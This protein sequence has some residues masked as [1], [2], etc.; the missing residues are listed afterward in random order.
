MAEPNP[1]ATGPLRPRLA[2][3]TIAT[4]LSMK[5]LSLTKD[6]NLCYNAFQESRVATARHQF[7]DRTYLTDSSQN[8]GRD[9]A[10]LQ[11]CPT[12][13]L[14]P[15]FFAATVHSADTADMIPLDSES[16]RRAL[17][18]AR[19]GGFRSVKLKSGDESFQAVFSAEA[20][21]W[22][23]SFADQEG[24]PDPGPRSGQVE[25]P[26]VG[27][28]RW[29]QGTEVGA[30]IAV[31]QAV[32]EVLALGIANEIVSAHAGKVKAVLTEDGAAVE[33]GQALLEVQLS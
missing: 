31:G 28:V 27:I 25:A 32:G 11:S 23:E 8:L 12:F 26:V 1:Q 30:E 21:S 17:V 22:G 19:E 6:P 33:Y 3:L 4:F 20:L 14:D 10:P 29:A 7:T 5:S 24:E 15:L 13:L 18:T 16:I 2:P 9:V